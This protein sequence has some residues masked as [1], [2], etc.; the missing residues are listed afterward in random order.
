[1]LERNFDADLAVRRLYARDAYRVHRR[2]KQICW[3]LLLGTIV[4]IAVVGLL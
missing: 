1:M 4:G 3:L 2:Y